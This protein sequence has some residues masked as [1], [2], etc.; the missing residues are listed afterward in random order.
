MNSVKN[1]ADLVPY[2]HGE[3]VVLGIDP[4]IANTGYAVLCG[5]SILQAGTISTSSSEPESLRIWAILAEILRVIREFNVGQIAI[6]EFRAFYRNHPLE[7]GFNASSNLFSPVGDLSKPKRRGRHDREVVNPRSMFLMKAAQTATQIAGLLA[8]IPIFLYPVREWK[9][10]SRVSKETIAARVAT[11]YKL[12]VKNKDAVEAIW[13][14][15]HHIHYG[16]LRHGAGIIV[17]PD[18]YDEVISLIRSE[19]VGADLD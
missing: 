19:A 16:R 14:A 13:I 9:G 8:N 11:F 6:E 1:V 10:G 12:N 18:E 3:T 15:H 17:P 4:A 5:D 7:H 2:K